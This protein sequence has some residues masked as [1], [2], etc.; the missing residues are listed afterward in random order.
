MSKIPID[1]RPDSSILGTYKNQSYKIES[2]FAEFIDNSTQSFFTNRGELEKIGQTS[3]KIDIEIYPEYIKIVD[4]AFGMEM[5][6]F[7][8]ASKLNS[9]P[10]DRSGRS[11][12][13]MGLKT[14]A[15]CLGSFWSVE[16]TQ[17]H[18]K[19]KYI[20][21]MDVDDISINAPDKIDADK[22]ECYDNEHFTSIFIKNLNKKITPH[23][24]QTL[25]RTLSEIYAID[26]RNGDL[27]LTINK[28]PVKY[29]APKLWINAE[30]NSE[31]KVTFDREIIVDQQKYSFDGW[32]GIRETGDT[33][34]SGINIFRKD[35]VIK[36]HYRPTNLVGKSNSFSYQRIIGEV[37]LK[38]NNWEPSYTKDELMWEGELEE[39]FID[40]LKEAA[41]GLI[42]KSRE[43]RKDEKAVSQEKQKQISSNV[44][45]SFTTLNSDEISKI[46]NKNDDVV[47]IPKKDGVTDDDSNIVEPVKVTISNVEYTFN[48]NFLDN[49]YD[50]WI[51]LKTKDNNEY[52]SLINYG[53]DYF[54]KYK[55]NTDNL[56]LM[57]KIVITICISV[58]TAKN[59]GNRDAYKIIQIINSIVKS[60]K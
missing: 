37:Y 27:E 52:D 30:N 46:I 29:E 26:I 12:K 2:A 7:Q 21:E 34:F 44:T 20:I 32:I 31:Y 40:E 8:R 4:N 19:N 48:V 43:L 5:D 25:T 57:Q 23:K 18:S 11:E 3:V 47:D 16:T 51:D 39:K 1:I 10:E 6:E 42:K 28:V 15:T 60:I 22:Y 33:E 35:R 54:N 45:K 58:I 36:M 38:G 49:D 56:E 17:L 50:N 9:P 24:I 14:A 53:L 13:G 59:S 55:T 41:G